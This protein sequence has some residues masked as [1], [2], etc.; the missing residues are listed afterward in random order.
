MDMQVCVG[1]RDRASG[2]VDVVVKRKCVFCKRKWTLLSYYRHKEKYL[3]ADLIRRRKP[4]ARRI[5]RK[6]ERK[7][8][9]KNRIKYLARARVKYAINTGKIMKL[10]KCENCGS[11]GRIHGHHESYKFPLI[12]Q[13]LCLKCHRFIHLTKEPHH[14]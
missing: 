8:Y 4:E 7:L 1:H 3:A 6:L 14:A 9:L 13:W 12:V 2:N 10:E 5:R 11:M